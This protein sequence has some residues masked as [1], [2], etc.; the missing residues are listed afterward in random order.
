M[1]L[2]QRVPYP[3]DAISQTVKRASQPILIDYVTMTKLATTT[4]TTGQCGGPQTV[5]LVIYFL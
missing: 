3:Y 2:T 4:T 5:G 1:L